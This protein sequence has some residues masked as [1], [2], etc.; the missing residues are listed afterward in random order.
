MPA[1]ISTVKLSS[2]AADASGDAVATSNVVKGRILSV[3]LDYSASSHSNTDVAITAKVG[4]FAQP[5]L[6]ITN[7]NTDAIF[8][9]REAA[10]G[11]TG[12]DLVYD[13]DNKTITIEIPVDGIMTITVADNNEGETVVAYITMEVF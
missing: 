1:K 6:T 12:V 10:A 13:G 9:P 4:T 8:Y 2:G 11:L 5:V 7:A 3:L